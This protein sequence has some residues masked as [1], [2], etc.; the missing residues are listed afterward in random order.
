MLSADMVVQWNQIAIQAAV[1]DYSLAPCAVLTRPRA[2]LEI[3]GK[4]LELLASLAGIAL[5]CAGVE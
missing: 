4:H 5:V 2:P 3:T 1:N